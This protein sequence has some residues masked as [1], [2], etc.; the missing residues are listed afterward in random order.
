MILIPE[1]ILIRI[2]AKI[3]WSLVVG[4]CE[5]AFCYLRSVVPVP[6]RIRE[7]VIE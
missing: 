1:N 6:I 3:S 7:H 4:A 2:S 5:A